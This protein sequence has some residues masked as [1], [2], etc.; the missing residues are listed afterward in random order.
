MTEVPR[1]AIEIPHIVALGVTVI[2]IV[3]ALV[4][5]LRLVRDGGRLA[6]IRRDARSWSTAYG[7]PILVSERVDLPIAGGFRHRAIVLPS[8]IVASYGPT[9]YKAMLPAFPDSEKAI[10]VDSSL[11]TTIHV[12]VS[13]STATRAAVSRQAGAKRSTSPHCSPH[14]TRNTHSLR[15]RVSRCRGR[16]CGEPPSLTKYFPEAGFN[17]DVRVDRYDCDGDR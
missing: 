17:V 2:W 4:R 9:P 13:G 15:R 3:F 7:V 14:A 11:T 10:G 6:A 5:V 8:K 16:I 1:R 12:L